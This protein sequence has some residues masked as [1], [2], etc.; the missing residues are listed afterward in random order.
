MTSLYSKSKKEALASQSN[1]IY[2]KA[3][4]DGVAEASKESHD[5][6]EMWIFLRNMKINRNKGT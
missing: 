6:P 2:Q 5:S 1:D 4:H 3:M